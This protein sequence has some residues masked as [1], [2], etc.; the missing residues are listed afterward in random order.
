MA[1]TIKRGARLA[2]TVVAASGLAATGMPGAQAAVREPASSSSVPTLHVA[3][4]DNDMYVDGPTTLAAGRVKIT[5]ENARAKKDA[6]TE[7]GLLAPGYS[8]HDWRADIKK[9]GRNLFAPGGNKKKGLKAL[10]HAIDN[11]TIF[12]GFVTGAGRSEHGAVVVKPGSGRYFIWDDSGTVPRHRHPLTITAASGAQALAPTD[13]TVIAK[14]NRRFGGDDVLPARGNITFQNNSTES[15]HFLA[16]IHVRS[17]TTRKQVIRA[18]QSNN[19]NVF[20][21]GEQDVDVITSGQAMNVHLHL[22]PGT[23]AEACF[24]PDPKTGDP[25]AFMGMVHIVHLK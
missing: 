22:K 3:I 5:L 13:G 1:L 11:V 16:L 21:P 19:S 18:F 25:H 7:I 8:F 17:G 12:G 6:A 23:Y 20:L 4:T 9:V 2:L 24:F 15:P 10:N 14:T